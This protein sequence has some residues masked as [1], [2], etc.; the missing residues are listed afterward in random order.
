MTSVSQQWKHYLEF[1][2]SKNNQN[3]M[4]MQDRKRFYFKLRY[5]LL[6]YKQE[7]P[8]ALLEKSKSTDSTPSNSKS[9]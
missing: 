7:C 2:D 5:N 6:V 8:I 4:L 9:L 3:Y 1:Y